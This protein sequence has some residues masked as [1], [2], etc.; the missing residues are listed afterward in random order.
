VGRAP[1][2]FVEIGLFRDDPAANTR[3]AVVNIDPW[4]GEALSYGEESP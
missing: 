2:G 4:T 3:F 1:N